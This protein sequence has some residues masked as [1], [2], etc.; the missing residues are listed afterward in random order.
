MVR[1][2]DLRS[3][4]RDCGLS[5]VKTYIQSGNAI[6]SSDDEPGALR[7]LLSDAFE[8]KF[9]F[10]SD[11]V[12]RT[13]DDMSAVMS[14]W[15]FAESDIIEA[16]ANAPDVEHVHIY[17]S[18]DH[19]DNAALEKIYRSYEGKDKIYASERE[20]YLLC[21][22]SIWNSKLANMLTKLPVSLTARNQ[23]TV[24]KLCELLAG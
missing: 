3:L 5:D 4:F 21:Y 14:N 23:K 17:F 18:N 19:I 22:Q 20:L 11:V 24:R 1:M 2:D 13:A 8:K 10:H 6:F 12:L 16:E 7:D 15:P 9:G